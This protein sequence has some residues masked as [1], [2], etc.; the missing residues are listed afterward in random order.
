MGRLTT[1]SPR[2]QRS[3]ATIDADLASLETTVNAITLI[4]VFAY[5]VGESTLHVRFGS[6]LDYDPV[7][8]DTSAW[9]V[10][11]AANGGSAGALTTTGSVSGASGLVVLSFSGTPFKLPPE[12]EQAI[13]LTYTPSGTTD[14]KDASGRTV[15]G[16]TYS[17][18]LPRVSDWREA[19][20]YLFKEQSGEPDAPDAGYDAVYMDT[21][22][23]LN[24]KEPD[25]TNHQYAW[26][27]DVTDGDA[28]S[29]AANAATAAALAALQAGTE[30]FDPG[31]YLWPT[32]VASLPAAGTAGRIAFASDG[33]KVGEGAGAGTGTLCYDDG[34]AWRRVGDDTTVAA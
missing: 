8:L 13:V 7:D 12:E 25:G 6:E 19:A 32:T 23:R 29:E 21:D 27:T 3:I 4:P 16:F 24:S 34:T 33:R 28:I 11:L 30:P 20:Y 17:S 15:A 31:A 18:I 10:T 9:D 1:R 26:L 14:L 22:P 2:Y 5:V